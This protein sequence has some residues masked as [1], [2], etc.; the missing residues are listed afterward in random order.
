MT[1]FEMDANYVYIMKPRKPGENTVIRFESGHGVYA[2]I[3]LN[4]KTLTDLR[5]KLEEVEG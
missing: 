4:S 2:Y 1:R 5:E 3:S